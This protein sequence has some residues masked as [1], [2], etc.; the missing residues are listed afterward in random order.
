MKELEK[1]ASLPLPFA[2][3]LAALPKEFSGTHSALLLLSLE[4]Q[5]DDCARL[6]QIEPTRARA[7]I[8]GAQVILS[9]VFATFAPDMERKC[10]ALLA[11][12]QSDADTL[13]DRYLT[14]GVSSSLQHLIWQMVLTSI[15][16][17]YPVFHDEDEQ[18]EESFPSFVVNGG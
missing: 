12:H 2:N 1:A 11:G 13:V 16:A 9:D 18:S 7:L 3:F 5:P 4:H 14:P 17:R 6:C 15:R 10:R 8:E